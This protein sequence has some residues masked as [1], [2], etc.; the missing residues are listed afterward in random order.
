[1]FKPTT[2]DFSDE[3]FPELTRYIQTLPDTLEQEALETAVQFED[4]LEAIYNEAP[5]RGNGKFVWS[6]DPE[7]NAKGQ[8]TWFWLVK[9]GK[10]QTDGKHYKRQGKPPYGGK[11]LVEKTND[12]V[13]IIFTNTWE[14][15]SLIFGKTKKDTRL[16][17]HK[18]TGWEYAYPK[19]KRAQNLFLK[20]LDSRIL[21]RLRGTRR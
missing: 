20:E 13:F 4:E 6:L 15:S 1:M 8:R 12:G 21:A 16:P 3:L 14:K 5:P 2:R 10:V 18:A 9:T 19:Y 17:G 11:V 7:K